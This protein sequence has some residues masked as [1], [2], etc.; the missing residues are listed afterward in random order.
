[1]ARFDAE[2]YY[3]VLVYDNNGW[4][5]DDGFFSSKERA[6]K[7]AAHYKTNADENYTAR[8]YKKVNG[9]IVRDESG[10]G[11]ACNVW[12]F[13]AKFDPNKVTYTIHTKK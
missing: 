4:T 9:D 3:C 10:N 13:K 6:K 2:R 5:I 8:L 11:I 7:W 1:M 12:K